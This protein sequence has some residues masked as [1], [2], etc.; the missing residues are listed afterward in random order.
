MKV[1]VITFHHAKFSYGAMLQ[2]LATCTVCKRYADMVELINYENAYEQRGVKT[3]GTSLKERLL[4]QANYIARMVIYGGYKNPY[5]DGKKIDRIYDRLTDAH[6]TDVKQ[7][8][9]LEYD[10]MITGSDQVWNPNITGGIDPAFFLDFGKANRRISYAPSMGTYVIPEDQK[11]SFA[12]YLARYDAISVRETFAKDQLQPLC[13]QEVKV[14]LD[15]TLLLTKQEW[16]DELQ[17]EEREDNGDHYILTFF[18]GQ[19][20]SANWPQIAQYVDKLKLPVWNVQSHQKRALHVDRVL[21]TPTVADFLRLIQGADM[22]ITNSFHGTAFSINFGKRFVSV[23]PL[24]NPS[25]IENLLTKVDLA[26]RIEPTIQGMTESIDYD[27]VR[28]NLDEL[29]KDSVMW[30]DAAMKG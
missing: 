21:C 22:V 30:L 17:I 5:Q 3:K 26:S 6:Y 2:A 18:V 20:F 12:H 25:R 7:M 8:S 27:K 1:G 4:R 16:F 13:K 14:V 19:G 9:G 24:N 10:V 28:K 15:P 11:Q 29:R 23:L